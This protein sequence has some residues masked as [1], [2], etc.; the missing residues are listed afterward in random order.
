M[1]IRRARNQRGQS[2]TEY[3]VI[4]AVLLVAIIV[5][6]KGVTGGVN[7][8]LDRATTGFSEDAPKK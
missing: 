2:A 5:V 8:G 7:T 1:S 3:A 4:A 6:A